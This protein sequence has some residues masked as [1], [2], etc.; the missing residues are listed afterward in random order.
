[1]HTVLVAFPGSQRIEK[2]ELEIEEDC[3]LD[4]EEGIQQAHTTRGDDGK[5]YGVEASGK[6]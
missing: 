5:W 1:M 3:V 4:I 2:R 6:G